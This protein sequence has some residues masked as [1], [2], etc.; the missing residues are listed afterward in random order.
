MTARELGEQLLTVAQQQQ[1]P[2]MLMEAH[3]WI[4]MN[5][6]LIGE[7]PESLQH[8]EQAFSL[9]DFQQQRSHGFLYGYD[10]GVFSQI[11][12][13]LALWFLGY[14]D[15]GYQEL[16]KARALAHEVSPTCSHNSVSEVP[17]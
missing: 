7:V 1:D 14:P 17:C 9:Y 5:S 8:T 16:S 10:P 15:Q 13:A 3:V 11:Y 12:K 6:F 4:G 2:K